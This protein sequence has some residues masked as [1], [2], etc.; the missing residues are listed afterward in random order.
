ML[1]V[2]L[3]IDTLSQVIADKGGK[4]RRRRR[5]RKRAPWVHTS[6]P[7]G[8]SVLMIPLIVGTEST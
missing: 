8:L 2:M 1:I 5:R 3:M 4:R 6:T 7:N